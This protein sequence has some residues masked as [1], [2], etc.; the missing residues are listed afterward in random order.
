MSATWT[1]PGSSSTGAPGAETRLR[2][3]R[4]PAATGGPLRPRPATSTRFRAAGARLPSVLGGTVRGI[5]SLGR[6]RQATTTRF[7]V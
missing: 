7:R 5:R 1:S 6:G 4:S 2:S 3:A